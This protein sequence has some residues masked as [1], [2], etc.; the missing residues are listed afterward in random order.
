MATGQVDAAAGDSQYTEYDTHRLAVLQRVCRS[1][2][3]RH[4]D[5]NAQRRPGYGQANPEHPASISYNQNISAQTTRW[6]IVDWMKPESRTSIWAVRYP[7]CLP[8]IV[9]DAWLSP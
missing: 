1:Y 4:H 2:R 7:L 5:S 9:T 8:G 6:A 3:P